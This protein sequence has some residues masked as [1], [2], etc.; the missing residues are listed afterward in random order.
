M[1]DLPDFTVRLTVRSCRRDHPDTV[2]RAAHQRND[3][4][5][6]NRLIKCC[7]KDLKPQRFEQTL[8]KGHDGRDGIL[9]D[10]HRA[11]SPTLATT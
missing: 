10:I 9:I 3:E 1:A 4:E 6:Q 7:P 5:G 8:V 11:G 2:H